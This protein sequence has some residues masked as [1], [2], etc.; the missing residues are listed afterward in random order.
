MSTVA[1]FST[2]IFVSLFLVSYNISIR[3]YPFSIGTQ[4]FLLVKFDV[5]E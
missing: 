1:H 2:L 3:Q 4:M 5:F